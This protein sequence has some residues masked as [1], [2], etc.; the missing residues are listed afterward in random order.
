MAAFCQRVRGIKS[1]DK[2]WWD[3]RIRVT[4]VG[5]C[6]QSHESRSAD[7]S[8]D[9]SWSRDSEKV[10]QPSWRGEKLFQQNVIPN[11]FSRQ[12]VSEKSRSCSL[13]T[14]QLIISW[15]QLISI[16][17]EFNSANSIQRIQF[18]EFNQLNSVNS[19]Q[20]I[21]FNSTQRIQ[22]IQFNE[23]NSANWVRN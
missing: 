7:R 23:L 9:I 15:Y 20:R 14:Y 4:L 8:A 22:P 2:I 3:I 5:L 18:S 13:A 16:L 12:K 21:Q 11:I 17:I 19:I 1:V 6:R 10:C